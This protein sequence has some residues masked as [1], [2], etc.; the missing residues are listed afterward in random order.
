[1]LR[2]E[3][4]FAA[5]STEEGNVDLKGRLLKLLNYPK[6]LA[7]GTDI[8]KFWEAQKEADPEMYELAMI[9]LSVP[10][11]QVSVERCFSAVKLLL[12]QHRLQMSAERL[13][14]LMI[15]RCNRDLIPL[16]IELLKKR[17]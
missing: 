17:K 16:A 1:M 6:R 12:E 5:V 8:L 15:L 10:V 3:C 11:T 9:A 4:A 2:Q 13:N 7:S 14:D